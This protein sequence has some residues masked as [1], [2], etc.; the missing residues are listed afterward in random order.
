[1]RQIIMPVIDRETLCFQL[2]DVFKEMEWKTKGQ[3]R[4]MTAEE[5]R[6]YLYD[7]L[8]KE[9]SLLEVQVRYYWDLH[10]DW[11]LEDR[12]QLL[13]AIDVVGRDCTEVMGVLYG[14][15]GSVVDEKQN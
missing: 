2:E 14:P 5:V 1:M 7:L 4:P 10:P 6:I 12:D 11:S 3:E 9:P 13:H 8:E 15:D